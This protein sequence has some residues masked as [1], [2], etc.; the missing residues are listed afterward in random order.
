VDPRERIRRMEERG[1]LTPE[2]A[3]ML[4]ASL[5]TAEPPSRTRPLPP[6][7]TRM[8]VWAIG[9]SALLLLA[10]AVVFASVTPEPAQI[11]DVSRTINQVGGYGEM[12][13][14]LSAILGI[15]ILIIVPLLIWVFTHN[16]LVSREERV[17][18]A[19][20]D[21]ESN[22]QRRADLIPALVDTVSRYLEHERG[23]FVEVSGQ[24]ADALKEAKASLDE[25]IRASRDAAELMRERGAAAVEDEALLRTLA[26]AEARMGAGIRTVMAVAEAYPELRSSDQFLELQGQLEG[27]ENRINVARMRF[28]E[29]VRAYN[30]SI[31]YLPGS[32]VA[33]LGNFHRKA[34][35]QS[36]EEAKLVPA[37]AFQ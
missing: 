32:L 9:A 22:M 26:E 14:S 1:V 30:T 4:R 35:F 17:F 36:T 10:L 5:S 19:W 27:T 7:R 2:Q 12:N 18:E 31:R 6:C 24:R 13:R 28:N 25:L 8:T 20:A 11:D 16:S 21:T 3:A 34:Y 33:S 23:T 29:A 37:L 15:G